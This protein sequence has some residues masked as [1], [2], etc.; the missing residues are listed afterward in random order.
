M[1]ANGSGTSGRLIIV[2]LDTTSEITI[3]GSISN[4][5][6]GTHGFHVHETG[7]TGNNCADAGSHFNPTNVS[8]REVVGACYI[9]NISVYMSKGYVYC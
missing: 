3:Q 7:A 8:V 5:S 2:H 6:A 9:I 1:E 4:L